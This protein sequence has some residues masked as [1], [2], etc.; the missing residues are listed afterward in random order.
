MVS[1]CLIFIIER[2]LSAVF[3]EVHPTRGL[4]EQDKKVGHVSA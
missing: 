4:E 1:P 3:W 2:I